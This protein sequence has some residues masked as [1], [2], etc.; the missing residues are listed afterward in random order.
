VAFGAKS[1]RTD[2]TGPE[3]CLRA[4]ERGSRWRGEPASAARE[5]AITMEDSEAARYERQLGRVA[6]AM[7]KSARYCQFPI[8][9]LTLWIA[10]AILHEQIHFFIDDC[11]GV[12]GY[13]TWAFLEEDTERR[14][15]NDP[16]VLLHI[17]EWNEGDR[18]WILDFLV[19]YGDIRGYIREAAA[20]F[21]GFRE[22][23]SVRRSEE[24]HVRK[25]TTW[26]LRSIAASSAKKSG[27]SRTEY[28]G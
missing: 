23:K 4:G 11:G 3:C 10:P 16:R 9:C 12:A 8:A 28:P 27:V 26:K 6:S 1:L 13:M 20:I 14:F 7:A 22:A 2:A 15:L 24:G 19:V 18:L 5:T 25:V 17:S 21:D